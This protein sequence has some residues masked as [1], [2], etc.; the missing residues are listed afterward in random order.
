MVFPEELLPAPVAAA[1][2]TVSAKE[3]H[4]ILVAKC[5][6]QT[7]STLLVKCRHWRQF[8]ALGPAPLW[9]GKKGVMVENS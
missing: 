9:G 4:K 1:P 7:C 8:M 3:H 5:K 2:A 6:I